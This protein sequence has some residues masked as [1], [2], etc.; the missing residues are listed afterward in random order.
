MCY[1]NH[2]LDQIIEKILKYTNDL[3]RI[4]GR[5]KNEK[6]K[7]YEFHKSSFSP[8]YWRI[9]G[10]LNN[11]GS[12]M[13]KITSLID[14]R[15]RVSVSIVEREF[16]SLFRKVIDDFLSLVQKSLSFKYYKKLKNKFI[17]FGIRLVVEKMIFLK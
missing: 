10:K 16:S 6:V 12:Q 1:T 15:R 7:K 3:V 13:G 2:A 17:Y 9:I 5:C 4:G 8:N 11:L 14:V